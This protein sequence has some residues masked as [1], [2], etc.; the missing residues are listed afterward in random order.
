MAANTST[1]VPH[2]TNWVNNEAKA[3]VAGSDVSYLAVTTPHTGA[4]IARVPLSHA[5]DVDEAVGAAQAAYPGWSG[6]TFKDR[7]QFLLR[8]Y[9]VLTDHLD[10][11]AVLIV[12]EHGKTRDE[13]VGEIKKGLETLEY[14]IS[15]PQ[16]AAGRILEVSRGVTCHDTR[17]PLGV[18]ASVVP[19]NFPFMVPFWTLPIAV[20]CGNT[21][22]LKPSEKVPL[23]M[24]LVAR[25][26]AGVFPPGVFNLVH[27]DKDVVRPLLEHPQ[28]RAVTFVGTTKV[29]E[30]VSREC[31]A[32]NK[33]CLALG[34]AKNH[35]VAMPDCDVE[36]TAQDVVNSYTGCAGQRCMAASVL[37]VVGSQPQLVE[38]IVAKSR[39]L[40]PG[41]GPREVGPVIDHASRD[42]IL[43]YIKLSA[44]DGAELLVDG[45][46]HPDFAQ[47]A[48]TCPE[49]SWV[50]P[51]V[52]LHRQPAD[53][54]L[55]DEIFGP[56]L[57]ILQ[58]DTPEQALAIENANPYGN[59][60]CIYTTSGAV[61]QHFTGRFRAGMIGVNIGVP[62]PREPFSFGGIEASKFGDM[63]IT[64]D[65]GIE[66]FTYRRKVTTKWGAPVEKSWLN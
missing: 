37:L 60:A 41:S 2:L 54:A 47:I 45:R 3:C 15:L 40:R 50:G 4:T 63:D 10:E 44:K 9:R 51:T 18:V 43:D 35:L 56:V 39:A 64:G 6:R 36:L 29:A 11:L 53:A 30:L 61:A 62:V 20:G 7:A 8:F 31:R 52:I 22:V 49:G 38:A 42:R 32:L 46:I 48:T 17:V 34:G 24:D 57:S 27:G 65:G 16:T 58:V 12:S 19:F 28:V 33:R 5:A 25:L 55:H 26:A 14:A 1:T 59:A 23:T 21:F 13:A 66:F